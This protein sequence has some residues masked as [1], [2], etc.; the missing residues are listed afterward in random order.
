MNYKKAINKNYYNNSKYNSAS[1]VNNNIK[2]DNFSRKFVPEYELKLDNSKETVIRVTSYNILA[3]SLTSCSLSIKEEDLD[4]NYPYIKIE[5]RRQLIIKELKSLMSDI[6]GIQEMEKDL[7]FINEMNNAGYEVLFKPRPGEH[8]EGCGILIKSSKFEIVNFYSIIYNINNNYNS[9]PTN[10]IST[11]YDRDNLG[12]I[13]VLKLKLNDNLSNRYIVV[14]NT[15]LLYNKTRGDIKI[16]QIY[17]FISSINIIKNYIKNEL[18]TNSEV[19]SIICCDLN[20]T[21]NS[22]IYSL[23][24][25]GKIDFSLN[26]NSEYLSGQLKTVSLSSIKNKDIKTFLFKKNTVFDDK[27]H[28]DNNEDI[29]YNYNKNS[30]NIEEWLNNILKVE[31]NFNK[32]NNEI[33][34]N[35]K[36]KYKHIAYEISKDPESNNFYSPIIELPIKY[37]SAYSKMLSY[38][39]NYFINRKITYPFDRMLIND[40]KSLINIDCYGIKAGKNPNST[41]NFVD[42]LTLEP[43]FTN[44]KYNY[45]YTTDYIFYEGNNLDVVKVLNTPDVNQTICKNEFLPSIFYP[46]DHISI[47]A[48]FIYK[49]K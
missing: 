9:K 13:A 35:Y 49:Y 42:N 21:P 3:D 6:I 18:H 23:I 16:G 19:D 2:L 36:N 45:M 10:D 28:N 7:T 27:K 4:K 33:N 12:L 29:N 30:T 5:N 31:I 14:G 15:H 40:E 41:K 34:L 11:I 22:A 44:Y 20:S 48:D 46:S 38:I 43:P 26:Y 25:N 8:S 37:V 24:I 1:N 47:T 39:I 17:Q 32:D